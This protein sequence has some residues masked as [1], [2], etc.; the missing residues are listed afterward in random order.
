[1]TTNTDQGPTRSRR[2]FDALKKAINPEAFYRREIQN[3][4]AQLKI[5]N[6]GWT[7]NL[8]CPFPSHDDTTPSFGFNVKT[9]ACRCNGCGESCGSVID[10]AMSLHRLDKIEAYDYLK[11]SYSVELGAAPVRFPRFFVFQGSVLML[12]VFLSAER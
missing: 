6:E 10:A 11:S 4:P 9:G 7:Q 3:V 1:M 2:Q 12:P 5:N 8:R